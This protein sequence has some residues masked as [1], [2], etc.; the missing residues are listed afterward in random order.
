MTFVLL[1]PWLLAADPGFTRVDEVDGIVVETRPVAGSKFAE[2]RLTTTTS[3]TV[4]ALCNAAFANAR[5]TTDD[6]EVKL[7]QV[8]EEKPDERVTYDQVAAPMVSD[9]DYAVRGQRTH[10]P[11][12]ACQIVFEAANDRA[13]P[14][15]PGWV[16]I[17]QLRGSWRFDPEDGRTRITYTIYTDPGGSLPAFVIEGSR[18]RAAVRK[19]KALLAKVR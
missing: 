7:R 8:L 16:R 19:V 15:K 10:L 13:P 11:G 3:Q 14:L 5:D 18:R 17:E 6:P 1:L 2:L 9:R 12:G 4:D